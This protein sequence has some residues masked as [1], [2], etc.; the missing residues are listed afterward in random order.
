VKAKDF[1]H[2]GYVLRNASW[3]LTDVVGEGSFEQTVDQDTGSETV[4]ISALVGQNK[5]M[6]K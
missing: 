5:E 3:H 6:K 1:D 2:W 4:G